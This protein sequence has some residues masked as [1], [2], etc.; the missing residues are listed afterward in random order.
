MGLWGPL[1]SRTHQGWKMRVMVIGT[2]ISVLFIAMPLFAGTYTPRETL[3]CS[4]IA[5]LVAFV[6]ILV[7][8]AAVRC[9][10]CGSRWMWRAAKQ[11]GG[12]WLTWLRAQHL[13]PDCKKSCV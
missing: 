2:P 13:C 7:P 6:S 8:F 11:P 10:S 9:P 1:I 12:K 3:T 4:A 5:S